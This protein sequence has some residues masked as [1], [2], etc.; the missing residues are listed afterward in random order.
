MILK[1]DRNSSFYHSFSSGPGQL[2]FEKVAQLTLREEISCWVKKTQLPSSGT[3]KVKKTYTVLFL[4][5]GN[6]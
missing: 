1:E 3:G 4:L 6:T 2:N 5:D